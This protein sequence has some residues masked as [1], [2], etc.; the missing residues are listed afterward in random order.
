M[1]S[2]LPSLIEASRAAWCWVPLEMKEGTIPVRGTKGLSTRPRCITLITQL[3]SQECSWRNW[4]TPHITCQDRRGLTDI[5]NRY[6][7]QIQNL[8]I[9][10]HYTIL[11]GKIPSLDTNCHLNG[12]KKNSSTLSSRN[13]TSMLQD[14]ATGPYLFRTIISMYLG[15]MWEQLRK[16]C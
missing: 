5:R 3:N 8:K 4:E 15:A 14:T 16:I 10:C 1:F 12:K 2:F 9:P 13:F 11:L 7:L 6:Q